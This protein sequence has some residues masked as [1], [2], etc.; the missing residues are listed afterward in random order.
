MSK[1]Q[2]IIFFIWVFIVFSLFS[3]YIF[4]PN[5]FEPQNL[6]KIFVHNLI[7]S[8]G[9]YFILGTLRGLVSFPTTPMVLAGALIFPLWPFFILSLICIISSSIIAYYLS[10]YLGFDTY[11]KSK[12]PKRLQRLKKALG[13]SDIFIIIGWGFFPFVPTDMI[14]YASKIMNVPLWKCLLGL[15]IGKGALCA[16]YIFGGGNI[17]QILF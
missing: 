15:L 16:I 10:E 5:F 2:K 14:C 6:E 12:Y 13:K 9:I 8:F 11:F 17:F 1:R 3:L 7:I 4:Y